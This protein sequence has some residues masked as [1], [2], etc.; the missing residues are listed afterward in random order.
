MNHLDA[1]FVLL[2][3]FTF[4][5]LPFGYCLSF[6][7]DTAANA[8]TYL[9]LINI[10]LG[11]LTMIIV[12]II[13]VPGL[14]L[15]DTAKILDYVFC[16]FPQYNMARGLYVLYLNANVREICTESAE[17]IA[18]CARQGISYTIHEY[19]T[20][21]GGIGQYLIALGL[22]WPLLFAILAFVEY[23]FN[24]A[25]LRQT[26]KRRSC[27][28]KVDREDDEL[29]FEPLDNDVLVSL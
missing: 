8:L 22:L 21:K 23:E 18:N 7:F 4:A 5:Q 28:N 27:V 24:T 17:N 25:T 20:E 10:T 14:G 13:E 1:I 12:S 11:L 3:M 16:I 6:L 2:L 15:E 19:S 29:T 26:W 9:S